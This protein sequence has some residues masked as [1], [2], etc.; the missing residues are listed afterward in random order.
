MELLSVQHV[1]KILYI[2]GLLFQRETIN[3]QRH[4]IVKEVQ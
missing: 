4:T 2:T 1:N 3:Q